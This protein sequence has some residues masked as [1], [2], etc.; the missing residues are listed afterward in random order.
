MP[1]HMRNKIPTK[2][3]NPSSISE[4]ENH[5]QQAEYSVQDQRTHIPQGNPKLI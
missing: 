1:M 3:S 4:T 2:D 5:D